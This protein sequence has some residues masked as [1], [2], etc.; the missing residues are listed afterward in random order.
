MPKIIEDLE[1]RIFNATVVLI[2]QHGYQCVSMKMIAEESGIAVGTLY[3]YFADK[4]ELITTVLLKSWK[5]SFQDFDELL[6]SELGGM[7][8]IKTFTSLLY[9]EIASRNGIGTELIY[10]RVIDSSDA[11]FILNGIR[12]YFDAFIEK[13]EKEQEA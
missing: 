9:E 11:A 2:K 10:S 13:V 8:Q 1:Q 5:I 4:K 3:N 6:D 12:S 7:E